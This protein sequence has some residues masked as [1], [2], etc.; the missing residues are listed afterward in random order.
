MPDIRC[1][2]GGGAEWLECVAGA[3]VGG[4]GGLADLPKVPPGVPAEVVLVGGGGGPGLPAGGLLGGGGGGACDLLGGGGGRTEG[5]GGGA[6]EGGGAPWPC[7]CILPG[8]RGGG[9]KA[10][11]ECGLTVLFLL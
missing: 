4:A 9:G 5:G 3:L 11:C 8:E 7:W 2:G 1:G 6:D 10:L